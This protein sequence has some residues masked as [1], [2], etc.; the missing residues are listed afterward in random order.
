GDRALADIGRLLPGLGEPV[1]VRI[2]PGSA[3]VGRSLAEL[4]LRGRSGATVLAISRRGEAIAVPEA[5]ERLQ[6]GD[7]LGLTGSHEAI[8]IAKE[9]LGI[10]SPA[11]RP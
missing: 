7:I 9:L 10:A 5:G 11:A 8:A 2:E 1:A 3:G 4:N 6:P